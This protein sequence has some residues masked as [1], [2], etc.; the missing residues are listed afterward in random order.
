MARAT[1]A[2]IHP[3]PLEERYVARRECP[4]T[5]EHWLGGWWAVLQVYDDVYVES[6]ASRS[7]GLGLR[8]QDTVATVTGEDHGGR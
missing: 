2:D 5:L 6:V 1:S 8:P 7:Q 4:V 3:R